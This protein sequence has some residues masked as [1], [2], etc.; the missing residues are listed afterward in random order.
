[1]LEVGGLI[2]LDFAR[3]MLN[4]ARYSPALSGAGQGTSQ[5]IQGVF[6]TGPQVRVRALWTEELTMELNSK[7]IANIAGVSVMAVTKWRQKGTRGPEWTKRGGRYYYDFS[8]VI[9]WAIERAVRANTD[10]RRAG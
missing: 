8:T 6:L 4:R 10:E 5:K 9:R 2:G 1:M 7:D 3:A